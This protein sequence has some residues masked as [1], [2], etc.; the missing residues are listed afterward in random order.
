LKT[1]FDKWK[2]ENTTVL[3]PSAV[4]EELHKMGNGTSSV[5]RVSKESLDFLN[6]SIKKELIELEKPFDY[7]QMIQNNGMRNSNDNKIVLASYRYSEIPTNDV[8]LITTDKVVSSK[9][10]Y[11]KINSLNLFSYLA[12]QK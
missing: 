2:K 11:F 8:I 12:T 3:I 6:D 9:A 7:D 5:S 10:G 1:Y 4:M